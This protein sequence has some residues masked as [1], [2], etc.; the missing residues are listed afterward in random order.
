MVSIGTAMVSV[1]DK[2]GFHRDSNA[3]R[4]GQGWFP[5]GTAMLSD[6]DKDGFRYGQRCFPIGTRMVSPRDSNGFR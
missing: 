6:W 5:L 4:K 3:F 2:D 1:R